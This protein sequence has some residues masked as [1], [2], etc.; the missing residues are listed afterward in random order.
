MKM[1]S[2]QSIF[3]VKKSNQALISLGFIG[4]TKRINPFRFGFH[5]M[6]E[7]ISV[8]NFFPFSEIKI[9]TL[10]FGCF[11]SEGFTSAG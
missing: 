3:P 6:V 1:V 5:G 4:R 7:S 8:L 2:D 9:S 11:L 10:W